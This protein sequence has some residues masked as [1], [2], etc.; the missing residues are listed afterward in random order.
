MPNWKKLI[1]S[2]S[3]ASLNSL[4]V[5]T[6][7]QAL[8]NISGSVNTSFFGDEFNAHGDDANS[9]FTILSLG[10]KPTLFESNGILEIGASPNTDHKVY[11][12][13]NQ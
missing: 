10:S 9:G 3:D 8:G 6:S 5:T 1:T 11:P 13:T 2:G 7:I 4:S 12:L